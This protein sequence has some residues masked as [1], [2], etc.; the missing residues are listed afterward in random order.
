MQIKDA[1]GRMNTITLAQGGQ[2]H[3]YQ[4]VLR[5][6]DLIGGP[7]GVVVQNSSGHEYQVLRPL[8]NDFV[9]SMPRGATVVYPKD[10]GQI[11]QLADIYPGA[12]VVEAGV[13][14]GALSISLLRAVGDAGQLHS[15]ER[16]PEFAEIAQANVTTFFGAEHPAWQVHLKDAQQMDQD[17]EPGSVD[18]VVLDMLAPWECLDAVATVL[19][20]GG[21]WLNYIAT[22]TQMSR[23]AEAIREDGRFTPVEASETM[24]RGWH[25]D[26]LAVRPDHR[27]VAHTGF[28]MTC[29]RL[30]TGQE[31]MLLKKRSKVSEFSA[32]DTEAWLPSDETR[33]TPQALGERTVTDKKARKS[34]R[35]A[36][37]MAERSVR[38]ASETA[39]QGPTTAGQ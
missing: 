3:S 16:R 30:A 17:H 38:A 9:L 24:V 25:L 28:L 36:A 19:A 27:M 8:L 32:E 23:V 39:P 10:A 5:H 37:S 29:R 34:A 7:E 11:V 33:W 31:A 18:R 26:G 6:D 1:K 4:G 21:V 15:Y 20:P 12:T 13:G 35:E 22:A 2:F 14:S